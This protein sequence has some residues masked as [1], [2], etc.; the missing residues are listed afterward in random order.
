M[1]IQNN[2]EFECVV[3]HKKVTKHATSSRNHCNWCLVSLHVDIE[4]GDR[5]SE[6]RGIMTPIG[7]EIKSGKTQIVYRC[8]NCGKIGKNVTADDDNPDILIQLSQQ[9]YDLG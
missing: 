5:K 7:L 8:E 6:C 3:C 1:F 2:E 4:P 9:T